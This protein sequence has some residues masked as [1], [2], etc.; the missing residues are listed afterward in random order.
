[1]QK[2]ELK[3]GKREIDGDLCHM[4]LKK[5][6]KQDMR[7]DEKTYSPE[8]KKK[9]KDKL[10]EL[11]GMANIEANAC[12][13]DPMI[14]SEEQMDGYKRIRFTFESEI[15][16]VVPCYLLIPDTGKQK[17]P[18]AII[19]QG[20][21]SGFHNSIGVPKVEG[22]KEYIE[23]RGDF[24]VQAVKNGYATLCIEQRA[25]GERTTSRHTFDVRMCEFPSS[26][27][28]MLG[29]TTLGERVWDVQ[30]AIDILPSFDM[31]D[32]DKILI[33]GNSGGGTMSFYAGC[34]DERIKLSAPSCAFCSY[35]TSIL[36]VYHCTCN[37]IPNAYTHFEM[38]DLACL[39]APRN[40][41]VFA[42]ISDRIFP[43][44]GV[45]DAFETVKKIYEKE[46]VSDKCK[47]VVTDKAHWWCKDLVWKTL[48][49]ETAKMGW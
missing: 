45:K 3:K 25:M 27:G 37:Y 44:N 16:A 30:K 38:Q 35:A 9:V 14:E 36:D 28:M 26:T 22:D 47:L 15:G 8:Y 49:E 17:Y 40:F 1:M 6:I 23:T 41:V 19:L 11:L 21:S 43:I 48:N 46:N 29:R 39:I 10:Y 12:P 4:L 18:V 7:F 5:S 32:T 24:G 33:T 13:L 2:Y 42:G 31:L 34:M 20:H